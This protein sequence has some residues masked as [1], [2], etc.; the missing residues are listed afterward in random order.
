[1]VQEEKP[2]AKKESTNKDPLKDIK[3]TAKPDEALHKEALAVE[4]AKLD[5]KEKRCEHHS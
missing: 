3:K 5:V 1:M 4:D 2:V